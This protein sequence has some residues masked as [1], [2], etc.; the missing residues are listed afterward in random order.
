MRGLKVLG[1]LLVLA[2]SFFTVLVPF[3]ILVIII[4][5]Q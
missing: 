4:G 3:G 1:W 5:V 2:F